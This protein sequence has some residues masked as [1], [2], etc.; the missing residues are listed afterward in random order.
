VRIGEKWQ[1]R[2]REVAHLFEIRV[3][4]AAFR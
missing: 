2:L 3:K 4:L 1:S